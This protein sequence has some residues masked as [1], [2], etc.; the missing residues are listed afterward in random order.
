MARKW[1]R[2][3]HIRLLSPRLSP[4]T[5]RGPSRS[6]PRQRP[7]SGHMACVGGA[8]VWGPARPLMSGTGE[9]LD[10]CAR[11]H[12]TLAKPTDPP[13]WSRVTGQQVRDLHGFVPKLEGCAGAVCW[14][15]HA[16]H[17]GWSGVT[18][19]PTST[20]RS[21]WPWRSKPAKPCVVWPLATLPVRSGGSLLMRW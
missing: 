11:N 13:H 12:A 10:L 20:Y 1:L 3:G 21:P 19:P 4:R 16:A 14:T 8:A 6:D 18:F 7:N 9:R 5:R 15:A 2:I 17:T